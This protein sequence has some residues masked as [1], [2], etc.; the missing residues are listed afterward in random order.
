M[1]VTRKDFKIMSEALC[2][3]SPMFKAELTPAARSARMKQWREDVA[4]VAA[5]FSLHNPKFDYHKFYEACGVP[6][7]EANHD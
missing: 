4:A 3:A 6:P 1:N 7:E 5:V 2:H